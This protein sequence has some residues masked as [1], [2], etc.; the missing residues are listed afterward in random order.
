M[1]API[2]SVYGGNKK[3]PFSTDDK[4]DNP[5]VYM[6]QPGDVPVTYADVSDLEKDFCYKLKTSLR[7][8]L[9]RFAGWYY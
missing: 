7:E 4:V 9:R 8:G 2:Y 1:Y 5:V 3:A 6:L